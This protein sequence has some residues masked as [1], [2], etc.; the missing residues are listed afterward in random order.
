MYVSLLESESMINPIC[1]P[2][3]MLALNFYP[4][5]AR[6]ASP[7]SQNGK[8]VVQKQQVHVFPVILVQF[9]YWLIHLR[10]VQGVHKSLPA[11]PPVL[12]KEKKSSNDTQESLDPVLQPSQNLYHT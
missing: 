10:T 1:P 3:R 8:P 9:H 5:L 6:I 12:A 11:C 7:V 2:F 4:K